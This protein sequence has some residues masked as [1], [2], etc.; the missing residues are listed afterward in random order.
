[1]NSLW[2]LIFASPLIW[3]SAGIW[4]AIHTAWASRWAPHTIR[5]FTDDRFTAS[6][7]E[8]ANCAWVVQSLSS[9]PKL[10]KNNMHVVHHTL[11]Q[12]SPQLWLFYMASHHH[13]SFA[14]TLLSLVVVLLPCETSCSLLSCLQSSGMQSFFF[15]SMHDTHRH[16]P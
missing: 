14:F 13:S 2:H 6:H 9:L 1:M 8:D 4:T 10:L 11:S 16:T 15:Y 3:L 7:P 12:R 5:R